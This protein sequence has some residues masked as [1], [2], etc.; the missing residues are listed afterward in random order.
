MNTNQTAAPAAPPGPPLGAPPAVPFNMRLFIGIMG[1]LLSAMMAGLGNR[2]GALA[3]TDLRGVLGLGTDKGSW[4]NTVYLAGE[5]IAM[6]FAMWL[7]A[8]ISL[9]RFHMVMTGI[10]ALLCIVIPLVHDYS[11]LLVLRTLQ[12][13]SGGMLFP[14]LMSAALRFFPLPIRLYGMSLYAL[15]ATFAPNLAFWLTGNWFDV[16]F[17]WRLV[18]WQSLPVALLSIWMVQWGIPQD[19]LRPERL[20]QTDWLGMLCGVIGLGMIVVG[21]DQGERMDWLHSNL[22]CWLIGGSIALIAAFL[23]CQ[24]YHPM[25]FIRPQLLLQK[26]N[27]GIGFSIFVFMLMVMM[28]GT[29]LPAMHLGS[30]WGFRSLQTAP[31]GLMIALP[32]PLLGLGVAALLYRKWVDGRFVMAAGMFFVAVACVLCSKITFGWIVDQFVIAQVLQAVGQA[33]AVV[34]LLFMTT[35]VVMPMEGPF[36]AG[37]INTL[38]AIGAP[39]GGAVIDR[40]FHHRLH[41]HSEMIVDRV[42][43]MTSQV[44][45]DHNT[46]TSLT[47]STRQEAFILANADSFLMLGLLAVLLIPF[48]FC[49]DYVPPP[50]LPDPAQTNSPN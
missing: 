40:F 3:L 37:T 31:I 32:Q 12:G 21:L 25:P 42:G 20:A 27:L 28:S 4:L 41:F 15:T 11:S 39:F 36:V 16:L 34:S 24:W 49:L 2:V 50:V 13:L 30:Q 38:R 44:A 29:K 23:I 9:R 26:P 10:F 6:P 19:P 14:I 22:I 8:I 45:L 43:E 48:I 33:M 7:A 1:I 35:S 17:N 18:Y 5:V 47:G 46:L